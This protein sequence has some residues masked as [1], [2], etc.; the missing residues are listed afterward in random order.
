LNDNVN[1][2]SHYQFSNGAQVVDITENL[3]FNLGNTVKYCARAGR[4]TSD[5]LE[6][7]EKARFYLNREILRLLDRK[8]RVWYLYESIPKNVDVEDKDGDAWWG[9]DDDLYED[10]EWVNSHGPFTEVIGERG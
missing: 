2:P 1:N 7:L 6:D 5:A 8:A 9:G 10:Y 4:K 3:S